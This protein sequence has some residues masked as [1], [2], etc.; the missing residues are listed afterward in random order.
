M[1]VNALYYIFYIFQSIFQCLPVDHYW[2][3]VNPLHKGSCHDPSFVANSTYAQSGLS[4]VTDLTYAILPILIVRKLQMSRY[5]RASLSLMLGLGAVASVAVVVRIPYIVDL[6]TTHDFLWQTTDVAIWSCVEPG[7][8]LTILNLVVTRPLFRSVFAKFGD[9]TS[10]AVSRNRGYSRGGYGKQSYG[11]S[12]TMASTN[13]NTSCADPKCV[14]TCHQPCTCHPNNNSSANKSRT[15]YDAPTPDDLEAG[16][17]LGSITSPKQ[18]YLER[19]QPGI[20]KTMEITTSSVSKADLMRPGARAAREAR[21]PPSN[22]GSEDKEALVR[23]NSRTQSYGQ[24]G[25]AI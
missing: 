16:Y 5:K 17:A 7:L 12:T 13:G 10:A 3:R 19:E 14:C 22:R 4:I 15:F 21:M 25:R 8:G 24:S 1:L 2:N 6:A 18:A 20:T 11:A 9:I 23:P